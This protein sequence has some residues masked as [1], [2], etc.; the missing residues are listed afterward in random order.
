MIFISSS[1]AFLQ[2]KIIKILGI[3]MPVL[4]IIWGEKTL[5]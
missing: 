3:L 4:F 2:M 1:T 5:K